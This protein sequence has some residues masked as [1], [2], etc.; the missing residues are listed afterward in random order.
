[1]PSSP[2]SKLA[3]SLAT[4][5][6]WAWMPA[7]QA[8]V[9]G[10]AGKSATDPNFVA[11]WHGCA[12]EARKHGDR[13]VYIGTQGPAH[14]RTQD[15]AILEA[16][17][18]KL[19]GLAVSITNSE[20]LAG[21]SLQKAADRKVPV[22][23]FDSDL[24]PGRSYLRRSY[25]GPDNV[26]FGRQLGLIAKRLRPQ[27]GQVCFM[28]ADPY[29]PNLNERILGA[30]QHL[31]DNPLISKDNKLSGKAGWQ[32]TSRCPWYNGDDSLRAG[33]QT[34][35]ALT[36]QSADLVISV[37]AWPVVDEAQ[38]RR[39]MAPLRDE[40]A[41]GRKQ[42][43]IGIGEVAPAQMAL[44]K[45]GLV[46]A[47]VSID[48]TQMGRMAYLQLKRLATGRTVSEVVRTDTRIYETPA[49]PGK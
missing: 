45:E 2:P 30:R 41:S 12:D 46:H 16:L 19:D 10:L 23:T 1:M 29:S 48:F 33:A 47:Y 18:R 28:S 13:C 49:Q 44:L 17:D 36:K 20:W 34:A 35:Q 43:I 39:A 25:V 9:F 5:C 32:E 40:L 14:F 15:S 4:L 8:L 22:V 6:L 26:A 42:V 37:G 38:Y 7:A 31:E 11:A 3:A 27:G 21:S 24:A